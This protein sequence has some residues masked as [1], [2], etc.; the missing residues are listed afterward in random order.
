MRKPG[1]L[2]LFILLLAAQV[3]LGNYC[4]FTRYFTLTFLPVMVL[5]IPIKRNTIFCLIAAFVTGFICDFL[6]DGMLGLTILALVPVGLLRRGIIQLV[7]GSEVFSRGEDI[8]FRR[9]GVGKMALATA[10][11]TGIFLAIYILVDCAGTMPRWFCF[12]RW[13]ISLVGDTLI[14]L[15]AA[16]LLTK[17]EYGRWR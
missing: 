9:Q 1:F 7:F 5:C 13:L 16:D 8:S 14:G 2:L 6:Q 17:D 12:F 4:N 10:I 11:V 15:F 3:V